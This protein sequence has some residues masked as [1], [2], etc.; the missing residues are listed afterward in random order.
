MSEEL[1]TH[2][3]SLGVHGRPC[4]GGA[5]RGS[6]KLNGWL[7]EL[8]PCDELVSQVLVTRLLKEKLRH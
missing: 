7:N 5:L 2:A 6:L 3:E 1:Y 4:R 8:I